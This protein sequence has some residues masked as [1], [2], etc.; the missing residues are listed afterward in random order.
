MVATYICGNAGCLTQGM[1]LV[2]AILTLL[3]IGW[4]YVSWQNWT[5]RYLEAIEQDV[6]RTR[7]LRAME[8]GESGR[9]DENALH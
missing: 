5:D 6:H 4:I 9:S 1:A 3:L 2:A 8:E 7:W